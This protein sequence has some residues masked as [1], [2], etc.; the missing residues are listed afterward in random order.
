MA[1]LSS[2]DFAT[3][4]TIATVYDFASHDALSA[5]QTCTPR[6]IVNR[7]LGYPILVCDEAGELISF[8]SPFSRQQFEEDQIEKWAHFSHDIERGHLKELQYTIDGSVSGVGA[9]TVEDI[10]CGEYIGLYCGTVYTSHEWNCR[11]GA[12]E[13]YLFNLNN[14]AHGIVLDGSVGSHV[15]SLKYLNHSCD[16]NVLM[17]EA[18]LFGQWY[19]V[20]YAIQDIMAGTE[21]VHDYELTTESQKLAAIECT[22]CSVQCRGSLYEYTGWG[23]DSSKES[24]RHQ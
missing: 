24:T 10:A 12:D 17:E 15:N 2:T 7:D 8:N 19:V 21:L 9:F 22:C 4:T 23:D 3:C 13:T 18:Y 1:N 6:Y 16:P 14:G 5:W 20:V 11:E